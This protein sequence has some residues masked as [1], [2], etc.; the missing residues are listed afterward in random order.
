MIW[1]ALFGGDVCLHSIVK[2]QFVKNVFLKTI[3]FYINAIPEH[4]S[5]PDNPCPEATSS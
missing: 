4:R 2:H 3:Y 1:H 5:R